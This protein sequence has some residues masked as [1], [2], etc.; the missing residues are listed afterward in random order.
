S[1]SGE[2]LVEL[3]EGRTTTEDGSLVSG[4]SSF[5]RLLFAIG[6]LTSMSSL[7]A[8]SSIP[9]RPEKLVYPPI[10]Y[11]APAPEKF[12][13]QLKAGPVAYLAA[14]RELPLVNIV[15]YA[16]TGA[17]VEP[18]G[19]EGLAAL[20]GYLLAR[21]GIKSKTAE[22]LEERLAFLAAQLNSA[23]GDSQGTVS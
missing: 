18:S 12:R 1:V 14:D 11:E 7:F 4:H 6:A 15:V 9:D 19:K 20:T 22:E 16:H 13:V 3:S 23:A 5:S 17:Y 8:A 21:G 10:V 2:K